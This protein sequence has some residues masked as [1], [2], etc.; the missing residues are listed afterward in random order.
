M[1]ALDQHLGSDF[2]GLVG[3]EE[4]LDELQRKEEACAGSLT[5]HHMPGHN[6]LGRITAGHGSLSTPP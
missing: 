1:L 3:S 5:C 6:H 2:I 4:L